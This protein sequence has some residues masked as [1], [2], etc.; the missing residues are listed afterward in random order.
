MGI[1]IVHMGVN[2]MQAAHMA[3]KI[4]HY[5]KALFLHSRT[6][7]GHN[8]AKTEYSCVTAS[9][10]TNIKT[11]GTTPALYEL[12]QHGDNLRILVTLNFVQISNGHAPDLNRGTLLVKG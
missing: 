8:Q 10:G 6:S 11:V 3:G 4:V 7:Q 5:F 1:Y 2:D 9:F 12:F